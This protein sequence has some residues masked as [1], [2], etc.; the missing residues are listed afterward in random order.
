[1]NT[2]GVERTIGT[3][4]YGFKNNGLL[5]VPPLNFFL[6]E[7]QAVGSV[8]FIK[9]IKILHILSVQV[10]PLWYLYVGNT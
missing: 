9:S 2:C 5:S 6:A 10:V 4:T 7:S 8:F 1:M 3:I